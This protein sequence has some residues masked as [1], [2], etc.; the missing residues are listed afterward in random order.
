M[1]SNQ[2]NWL[3]VIFIE[4]IQCPFHKLDARFD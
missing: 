3:L 1:T 4:E 2:M